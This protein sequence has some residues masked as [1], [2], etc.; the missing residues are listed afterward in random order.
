MHESLQSGSNKRGATSLLES[1]A[2]QGRLETVEHQ[3]QCSELVPQAMDF[4]N[5]SL[6]TRNS[7]DSR[8]S[9]DIFLPPFN[10]SSFYSMNESQNIGCSNMDP[11]WL[12]GEWAGNDISLN[13][14]YNGAAHMNHGA[15]MLSD[16]PPINYFHTGSWTLQFRLCLEDSKPADFLAIRKTQGNWSCQ[17]LRVTWLTRSQ[18]F[19]T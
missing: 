13:P 18:I 11:L 6:P 17:C 15:S 1:K 16:L 8:F 12:S 5:S 14:F 4:H 10:D 7:L 3:N 9:T 19:G 2:K